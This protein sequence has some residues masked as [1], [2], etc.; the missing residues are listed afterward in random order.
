MRNTV[1][2]AVVMALTLT[3]GLVHG[4]EEEEQ[5]KEKKF[6]LAVHMNNQLALSD[7]E[8]NTAF[9]MFLERRFDRYCQVEVSSSE[10]TAR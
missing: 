4:Q 6:Q 7:F 1:L 2:L 3:T 9:E 5:K 10:R 8:E